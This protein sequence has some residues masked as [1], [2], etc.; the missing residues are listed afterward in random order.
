MKAIPVIERAG[1][2]LNLHASHAGPTPDQPPPRLFLT[3]SREAG[4]GAT[5]L[6]NLLAKSLNS[7]QPAETR[8]WRIFDGNLVEAMLRDRRYQDGL[9]RY[10]PEDSVS[11]IDATVGELLGLHPNLWEMIQDTGQLIRRLATEGHCILIGRGANFLT[12]DIAGG[13]HLRLIGDE[14]ERAAHMAR[15]LDISV[16]QARMRNESADRARNRYTLEHFNHSVADAS[17]Y[18]AIFSTSQISP[19]EICNWLTELIRSR[20]GRRAAGP[21]AVAPSQPAAW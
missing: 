21:S 7:G 8:P 13:L 17:G 14:E 15:K 11:E 5:T 3:I 4:A 20:Q 16:R 18:D 1:S 2:Y 6:A 19:L 12:R 9:A 10:L